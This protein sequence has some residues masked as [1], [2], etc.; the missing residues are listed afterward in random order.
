MHTIYWH[1]IYDVNIN[2]R[3][4]V[5]LFFFVFYKYVVGKYINFLLISLFIS[6]WTHEYPFYPVGYNL[7]KPLF[8]LMFK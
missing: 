2:L 3:I 6:V 4:M 8:T 7:L 1:I 5:K